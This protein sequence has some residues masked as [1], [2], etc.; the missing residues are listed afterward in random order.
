MQINFDYIPVNRSV[1]VD[2]ELPREMDVHEIDQISFSLYN[3]RLG[4]DIA[5]KIE[6]R[7]E[8]GRY[9]YDSGTPMQ[10]GVNDFVINGEDLQAKYNPTG[11]FTD[12]RIAI[13]NRGATD[14]DAI[15]G[16]DYVVLD[17][18]KITPKLITVV[19]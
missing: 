6:L 8:D 5:Y 14:V 15:S 4:N 1:F 10:T 16:Q 3:P 19:D 17:D 7:D 18:F 12:I 11:K 2:H 13:F 9:Y